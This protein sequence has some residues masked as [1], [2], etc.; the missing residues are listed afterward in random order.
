MN[1]VTY[2]QGYVIFREGSY[3]ETM[4]EIT[5]GKVGIFAGYGT[6]EERM[7]ATLGVGETFGEMGL[8]EF[9]PRSA[10]AVALEENTTADELDAD[11]FKAYLLT[12]P[13]KTLSIMRQLSAR[14]RETDE[15]YEEACNTVYEAI[16]AEKMGKRRNKSLRSRLSSMVRS[17]RHSDK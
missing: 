1:Q 12:Q 17:F 4:Y 15:R 6:S 8:I 9:W 14:L 16:E 5:G 2:E 10:T 3:G 13:E 11:E 7:L